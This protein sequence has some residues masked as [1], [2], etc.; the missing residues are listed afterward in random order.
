[1]EGRLLTETGQPWQPNAER[2]EHGCVIIAHGLH[3]GVLLRPAQGE[4]AWMQAMSAALHSRLGERTPNIGLVD[5]AEAANPTNIHRID[6]G[7][8][9]AKFGADVAGIRPE[10]QEIGDALA[11]RLAQY[12]LEN[13]IRRDRPLH[14]IGHSAGGF[15]VARAARVLGRM[16]LAPQQLQVTILDTPGPDSEM[17]VELPKV[18]T[19]EFYITSGFVLGLDEN[20]GPSGLHIRKIPSEKPLSLLQAHSF[21]HDWFTRTIPTAHAGD[22]GFGRSP[23]CPK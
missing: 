7:I 14:L 22:K 23:F 17:L 13:K 9:A 4:T 5:W 11:F 18:C 12:I 8:T 16:N 6:P 19:A 10:A 2:A 1:V 3:D 20:T 15:V 21:A